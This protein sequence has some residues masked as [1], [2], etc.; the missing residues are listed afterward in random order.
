MKVMRKKLSANAEDWMGLMFCRAN[1]E[2]VEDEYP[3][4]D[5][6]ETE[7]RN[8]LSVQKFKMIERDMYMDVAKMRECL[9]FFYS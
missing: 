5:E 6:N 8:V 3:A 7:P 4:D 2:L 1:K 9:I